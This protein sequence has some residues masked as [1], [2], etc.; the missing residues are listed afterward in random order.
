MAAAPS[1]ES[2]TAIDWTGVILIDGIPDPRDREEY[3]LAID[4]HQMIENYQGYAVSCRVSDP[5]TKI[6]LKGR[7]VAV[8]GI[9]EQEVEKELDEAFDG[10]VCYGVQ[11]QKLALAID[12]YIKN[13]LKS[14]FSKLES[15]RGNSA[16]PTNDPVMKAKRCLSPKIEPKL[17]PKALLEEIKRLPLE[18]EENFFALERLVEKRV[19]IFETLQE[20]FYLKTYVEFVMGEEM[21]KR[22]HNLYPLCRMLP[23]DQVS[24]LRELIE[25]K[26]NDKLRA[27]ATQKCVEGIAEKICKEIPDNW[28]LSDAQMETLAAKIDYGLFETFEMQMSTERTR[29]NMVAFARE[30][31][32]SIGRNWSLSRE[33]TEALQQII[34]SVSFSYP[35]VEIETVLRTR[36]GLEIARAIREPYSQFTQPIHYYIEETFY[37]ALIDVV[38][39]P[40]HPY[41]RMERLKMALNDYFHIDRIRQL[42][43][44][45]MFQLLA[46]YKRTMGENLRDRVVRA[47]EA[48]KNE[49]EIAQVFQEY[50]IDP[51]NEEDHSIF[52]PF[53]ILLLSRE[54]DLLFSYVPPLGEEEEIAK[55]DGVEQ[56]LDDV[57]GY[58]SLD[59][60]PRECLLFMADSAQD[61]LERVCSKLGFRVEF[62]PLHPG[63]SISI[64]NIMSLET[65]D[66]VSPVL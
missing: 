3:T 54:N 32:H 35:G 34:F 29:S 49:V 17:A 61:N 30:L 14:V 66:S 50:Q 38:R 8:Y 57:D 47:L 9:T 11:T 58:D 24:R 52:A 46:E 4:P 2:L 27:L 36:E 28:N 6:T 20:P 63:R 55:V 12:T 65:R 25:V 18:I 19:H 5:S 56:D 37:P 62:A 31:T 42:A 1:C 60:T 40:L 23:S 39:K 7:E 45:R 48:A 10:L 41:P 43:T 64:G 33:Q 59:P 22:M 15:Q 51:L 13:E 53:L 26:L 21:C 44:A 16:S